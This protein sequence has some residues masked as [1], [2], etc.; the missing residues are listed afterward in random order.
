M[1][2]GD[3]AFYTHVLLV[4]LVVMVVVGNVVVPACLNAVAEYF[5]RK[6]EKNS[7]IT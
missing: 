7:G 4:G 1:V 6:K 5:A 3:N 2:E